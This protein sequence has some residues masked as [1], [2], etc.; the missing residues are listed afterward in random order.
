MNRDVDNRATW[1]ENICDFWADTAAC[2]NAKLC[3]LDNHCV[4][5]V[6]NVDPASIGQS[7]SQTATPGTYC[8]NDGTTA[9]GVCYKEGNWAAPRCVRLCFSA[10]GVSNHCPNLGYCRAFSRPSVWGDAVPGFYNGRC[11]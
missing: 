6:P 3:T 1:C 7:C 2:P 9:R 11:D 5:P 10:G 8:G 4:A